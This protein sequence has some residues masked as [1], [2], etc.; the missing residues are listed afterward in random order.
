[1][2]VDPLNTSWIAQGASLMLEIDHE[3]QS[4]TYATNVIRETRTNLKKDKLDEYRWSPMV[5][6]TLYSPHETILDVI[7]SSAEPSTQYANGYKDM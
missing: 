5:A 2:A 1:M 7:T 6:F 3:T 4:K